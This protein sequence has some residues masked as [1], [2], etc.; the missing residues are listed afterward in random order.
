MLKENYEFYYFS[1]EVDSKNGLKFD[2][3]LKK[4]IS[5]T[6]NAIKLLEY[7]GYQKKL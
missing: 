7:V 6:R 5:K 3:K 2:Y 1:E 4:G